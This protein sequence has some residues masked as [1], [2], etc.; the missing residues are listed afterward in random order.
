MTMNTYSQ[1][2]PHQ[3]RG[4]W[5]DLFLIY[6]SVGLLLCSLKKAE[7]AFFSGHDPLADASLSKETNRFGRVVLDQRRSLQVLADGPEDLQNICL[8]VQNSFR[9][10]VQCSC[11]GT[12]DAFFSISCEYIDSICGP[13]GDTCGRPILTVSI[14]EGHVFSATSCI[15][16]Y[17]QGT[18]KILEDLCV[19]VTTCENHD[20]GFC[21]CI[22]TYK[23]DV[24]GKCEICDNGKGVS[25]DCTS[26]NAEAVSKSCTTIDLDLDLSSGGSQ[27]A[28]FIPEMSGMCTALEQA[29]DNHISC[30]CTNAIGGAYTINCVTN[31]VGSDIIR[32]SVS[33]VKGAVDSVTSCTESTATFAS[34]CT[35]LQFCEADSEKLCACLATYD[36][37]V[38]SSCEVCEGGDAVKVDCSNVFAEAI[39]DKCQ[40]VG[41]L[42]IY[43]FIPSYQY[44]N[45]QP[46]TS[47][48]ERSTTK[49]AVASS[50]LFVAAVML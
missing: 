12:P 24:C 32:S 5:S 28:G 29:L 17:R 39:S 50:A 10:N 16:D 30:D 38:C 35:A 21:E 27:V 1:R 40:E 45:D 48:G 23:N 46:A 4:R 14:V 47:F 11:F 42:S 49:L 8:A 36:A 15:R 26:I 22:A 31:D 6:L 44:K 33:I 20:N 7:G 34:T 41:K 3:R 2:K 25:F 13:S 43:E 18:S 37:K 19:A 9:A